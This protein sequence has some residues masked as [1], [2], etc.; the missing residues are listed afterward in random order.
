M[1]LL[2]LA[3]S[4]LPVATTALML[5]GSYPG[6]VAIGLCGRFDSGRCFRRGRF[7]GLYGGR[8]LLLRLLPLLRLLVCTLSHLSMAIAAG[9]LP[10]LGGNGGPGGFSL[11][12]HVCRR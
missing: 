9:S 6:L 5:N 12:L 8:R 3:L 10:I 7:Y 4:F 11:L 1:Y 2:F